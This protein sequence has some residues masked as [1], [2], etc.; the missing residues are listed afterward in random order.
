MRA[1]SGLAV[2]FLLLGC[3]STETP[4]QTE[5]RIARESQQAR[6]EIETLLGRWE[7]WVAEGNVDSMAGMLAEDGHTLPP[8]LPAIA[9][10]QAWVAWARPLFS[11]GQWTEDIVTESV[12]ANGPIAI[13][14]G[15]YTLSMTP[16]PAAPQGATAISDTGKYLWHWHKTDGRWMLR[17][18]VWNSDRPVQP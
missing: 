13:E 8:N 1:R 10:R 18:A 3:Q 16:G 9:G 15:R 2:F 11:Q 5:A 14:R 4:Q 17:E 12:V 7:G 6:A